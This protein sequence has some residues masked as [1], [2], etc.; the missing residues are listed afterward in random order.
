[1]S[2]DTLE[3]ERITATRSDIEDFLYH[4]AELLDEW[5]LPE[6]L[7]LFTPDGRYEV[8]T[9]TLAPDASADES[10]FY[11]ADDRF[12]IGER[13]K[14]L[15]KRAA[16]AEYPHSKTTRLISNVRIDGSGP[17]GAIVTCN[18]AIYRT[19]DEATH[20]FFGKFRY[21][22]VQIDGRLRI[23]TKRVI[24]KTN[25]LREQGRLSIIL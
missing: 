13:V 18:F 11:I 3:L 22:L 5:M 16:H 20:V 9:T 21:V 14:R 10:L 2:T 6:W 8:P 12:R 23:R 7:Q 4:E 19:K 24:L 25:G 15:M 17:D 1:M